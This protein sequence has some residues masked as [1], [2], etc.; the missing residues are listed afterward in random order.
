VCRVEFPGNFYE[1]VSTEGSIKQLRPFAPAGVLVQRVES[2]T[3]YD[4]ELSLSLS[5]SL[6]L[7]STQRSTCARENLFESPLLRAQ[8]DKRGTPAGAIAQPRRKAVVGGPLFKLE[9]ARGS[10]M[11]TAAERSWSNGSI[12]EEDPANS[13]FS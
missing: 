8:P 1:N 6:S 2:R 5:L 9:G 13:T 11:E 7:L 3:F 4:K 12:R 10:R